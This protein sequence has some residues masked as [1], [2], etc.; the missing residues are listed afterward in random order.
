[1]R[2]SSRLIDGPSFQVCAKAVA[3]VGSFWTHESTKYD[4]SMW[5]W[6]IK[7][8]PQ[9]AQNT[10]ASQQAEQ[11]RL[12]QIPVI[13]TVSTYSHHPYEKNTSSPVVPRLQSSAWD[14]SAQKGLQKTASS[15]F[16]LIIAIF[17]LI[18][19]FL[20]IIYMIIFKHLFG[21]LLGDGKL[22]FSNERKPTRVANKNRQK[23]EQKH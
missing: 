2:R 17:L 15:E 3:M 14:L 21:H 4:A 8:V 19:I 18:I 7:M 23:P 5:L 9:P 6:V 20:F 12:F 10:P 22:D 13:P 11:Q 1:M 16:F